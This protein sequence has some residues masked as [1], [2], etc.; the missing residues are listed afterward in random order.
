MDP[1]WPCLVFLEIYGRFDEFHKQGMR[2]FISTLILGVKLHG[3]KPGVVFKFYDFYEFCFRIHTCC[4]KPCI[5][6]LFE[7]L[8]I[9]SSQK[10]LSLKIWSINS[11]IESTLIF[12]LLRPNLPLLPP[13][14]II[15]V[16]FTSVF[17]E[18]LNKY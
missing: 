2:T 16:N 14:N 18:I 3:N 6:Q 10:K 8:I 9:I 15:P 7:V 17:S 4:E 13:A 11:G 12:N 1:M 5:I